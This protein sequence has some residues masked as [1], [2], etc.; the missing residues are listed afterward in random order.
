LDN[1]TN[2]YIDTLNEQTDALEEQGLKYTRYL[3]DINTDLS[4]TEEAHKTALA[5]INED[6]RRNNVDFAENMDDRLKKFNDTMNEMRQK[7]GDTIEDLQHDIELEKGFGL[8]ADQEKLKELEKRLARENRDYAEKTADEQEQYNEDIADYTKNN[9]EKLAD[10][11]D[12]L[13]AEQL[14]YDQKIADTQLAME[15][16][17][18]D[19]AKSQDDILAKTNETLQGIVDSY[20]NAF[21]SIYDKIRDSGVPDLLAMLPELMNISGEKAISG[22]SI[23]RN[24]GAEQ[25]FVKNWGGLYGRL[26]NAE[27]IS[28]G[29]Y[30]TTTGPNTSA[31]V[32]VTINN[33]VVADQALLDKFLAQ[34]KSELGKALALSSRGA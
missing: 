34:A 23:P 27:E 28:M 4:R 10:F 11:Q 5:G 30:G 8:R 26:P 6:I 2:D 16:E 20:Q 25:E 13:D 1:Y 12:R 9:D 29:V 31:G 19:Y 22:V 14:A 17:A 18:A 21:S 32:N 7:H 3:E 24:L 15:R 33:P